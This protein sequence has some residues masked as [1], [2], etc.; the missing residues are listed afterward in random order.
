MLDQIKYFLT[1]KRLALIVGGCVAAVILIVV[2]AVVSK[3]K[4]NSKCSKLKFLNNNRLSRLWST[5]SGLLIITVY[6][7]LNNVCVV[8][9]LFLFQATY[10][11]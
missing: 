5:V 11:M 9:I 8:V 1:P 3:S 4:F 10:S 7:Q 2:I 6:D